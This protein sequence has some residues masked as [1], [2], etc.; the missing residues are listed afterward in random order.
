[1][2]VTERNRIKNCLF[3]WTSQHCSFVCIRK[4]FQHLHQCHYRNTQNFPT[5]SPVSLQKHAKF[6]NI[7]TS[8]LTEICKI[9]FPTPSPVSTEICKIFQHLYQCLYKNMQNFPTPS[10]VSLQKYAKFSN[11]FTSVRTEIRKIF[12]H[13]HQWLYRNTQNFP[14]PSPVSLQKYAEFSNTF[15]SAFTEIVFKRR[16]I[17]FTQKNVIGAWDKV[18]F[19]RVDIK[20]S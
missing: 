12:Q 3:R 2:R 4:I 10:P 19:I 14:K 11:T 13:L 15:T 17:I 6:S 16:T 18:K 8:V 5:P 20:N 9:N 7:F 1:M